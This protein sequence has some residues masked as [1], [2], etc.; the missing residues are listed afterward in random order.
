MNCNGPVPTPTHQPPEFLRHV[1]RQGPFLSELLVR[2]KVWG[3]GWPPAFCLSW[4][5]SWV[6]AALQ[7]QTS[8]PKPAGLQLKSGPKSMQQVSLYK[9]TFR[10]GGTQGTEEDM[11]MQGDFRWIQ[12]IRVKGI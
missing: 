8:E 2:L 5:D 1:N 7:G 11:K 6:L 12:S 10:W 9:S 3:R 4:W